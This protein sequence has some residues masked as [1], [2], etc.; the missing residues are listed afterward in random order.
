MPGL[1][2]LDIPA[3]KI[4]LK[5]GDLNPLQNVLK[6]E[7]TGEIH[8]YC[9]QSQFARV[10][11]RIESRDI[12]GLYSDTLPWTILQE[13]Y[14]GNHTYGVGS[15]Y[16]RTFIYYHTLTNEEK[17]NGIQI[18]L[19]SSSSADGTVSISSFSNIQTVITSF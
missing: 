17:T 8:A 14:N 7:I 5:G 13:T 10:L 4:A 2:N 11:I 12:G 16:G 6:I 19:S 18:R 9:R 1:R 15:T 3:W